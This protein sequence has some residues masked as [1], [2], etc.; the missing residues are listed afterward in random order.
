ME[1]IKTTREHLETGAKYA[2]TS[3]ALS[4]AIVGVL[5]F[6]FPQLKPIDAHIGYLITFAINLVMVYVLKG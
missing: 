4:A 2:G 1:Q 5:T 6:A 3:L